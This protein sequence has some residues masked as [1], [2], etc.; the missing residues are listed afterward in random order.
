[1]NVYSEPKRKNKKVTKE[2]QKQDNNDDQ[3]K[4]KMKRRCIKETVAIDF[5]LD[6]FEDPLTWSCRETHLCIVMN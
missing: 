3:K 2:H 1:M 5:S 4:K 6:R